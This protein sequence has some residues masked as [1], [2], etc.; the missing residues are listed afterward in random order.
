M[1]FFFFFFFFW[2]SSISVTKKETWKTTHELSNMQSHSP[3]CQ[4]CVLDFRIRQPF[5]WTDQSLTC[6]CRHTCWYRLKCHCGSQINVKLLLTLVGSENGN[7]SKIMMWHVHII[8]K[9]KVVHSSIQSVLCGHRSFL[10]RPRKKSTS[11]AGF[12]PGI[13]RSLGGRLTT[14]P[15]RR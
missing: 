8:A 13:F 4:T 6:Y 5:R 3:M 2:I 9:L 15:T 12:E 14:R 11:Q 10:T 7:V 1:L